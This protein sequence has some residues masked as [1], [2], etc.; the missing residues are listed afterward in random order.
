MG[1]DSQREIIL[2]LKAEKEKRGWSAQYI[3]TRLEEMGFFLSLTTVK[4]VFAAGSENISFRYD[5]TLR[6]LVLLLLGIAEPIPERIP[7][8]EEQAEEYREQ[9]EN[10]KAII[11]IKG[12]QLEMMEKEKTFLLKEVDFLRSH[13]ED[14]KKSKKKV[15]WAV[16]I[17]AVVLFVIV[18]AFI[19]VLIYDLTNLDR[20]WV[21]QAINHFTSNGSGLGLM[22]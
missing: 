13:Y 21:Q 20:G 7:G 3:V 14:E 1:M 6:P 2:A 5:E 11:S 8:D 17:L 9:L 15:V 12:E 16:V 10:Y 19:G 4:R 18:S 22:L